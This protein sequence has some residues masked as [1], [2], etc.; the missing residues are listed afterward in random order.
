MF[1]GLRHF[2]IRLWYSKEQ[3]V[4]LDFE[5]PL[6]LIFV[7]DLRKQSNSVKRKLRTKFTKFTD[8]G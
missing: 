4:D 1:P 8:R 3:I 6:V 7:V 2:L 5:Q